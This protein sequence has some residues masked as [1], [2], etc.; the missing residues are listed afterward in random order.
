VRIVGKFEKF[1]PMRLESMNAPIAGIGRSAGVQV[2][3]QVARASTR[4]CN[5]SRVNF[6]DTIPRM[7][8]SQLIDID[9]VFFADV[10]HAIHLSECPFDIGSLQLDMFGLR[11]YLRHGLGSMSHRVMPARDKVVDQ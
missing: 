7:L 9:Q 10:N 1:D 8:N 11:I 4:Q 6:A 3:S 5:G 2:S